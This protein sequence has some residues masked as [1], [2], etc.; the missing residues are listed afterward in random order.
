MAVIIVTDV[1]PIAGRRQ[2]GGKVLPES[3]LEGD[4]PWVMQ[5]LV[6]KNISLSAHH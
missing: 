6:S 3:P 2:C 1:L 5:L 4:S